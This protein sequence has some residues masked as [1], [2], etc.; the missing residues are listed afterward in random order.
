MPDYKKY[1]IPQ[2]K[3]PFNEYC[4]PQSKSLQIPQT[5]IPQYLKNNPTLRGLLIQWN[6]GS[7]KTCLAIQIIL[8]LKNDYIPIFVMP[9][10]LLPNVYPELMDFCGNNIYMSK[11]EWEK[12]SK[13][14][15]K[16]QFNK[17]KKQIDKDI[18]IYSYNKF[19]TQLTK[20]KLKL[21]NTLLILDEVQNVIS[22]RGKQY[23]I[24][25]NATQNIK[26]IK[27]IPMSATPIYDK[28]NE[29]A[30][31]FNLILP[32]SQ[33]FP[34]GKKFD[35]HF[36]QKTKTKEIFIN[37]DEYKQKIHGHLSYYQGAPKYTFP[38][39][40][41]K[42]KKCPMSPHQSK[43]YL[44]IHNTEHSTQTQQREI[45]DF[46]VQ[47][48]IASNFTY[49]NNQ[50]NEQSIK[51]FKSL[52]LSQLPKYS[53]KMATLLKKVQKSKGKVFIYTNFLKYGGIIP[54]ILSL[55]KAGYKDYKT[56]GL[57]KK[58]FAVWSS[59]ETFNDKNQ[60]KY[61]WNHNSNI[62]GKNI[63]IIIGSP[64]IKEGIS[65][66]ALD[67][68]HIFDMYWNMSR[69][70]QIIGRGSRYCSHKQLPKDE[71]QLLVYI[72]IAILHPNYQSQ[73]KQTIDQRLLN[74]AKKKYS[75]AKQF[76]KANIE[77]SIDCR[78]NYHSTIESLDYK[79]KCDKETL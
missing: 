79:L 10:N 25:Y 38:E 51:Q 16:T 48:R 30:L 46:Y 74:I 17:T 43:F 59:K 69:I 6:M 42:Y 14:F 67:Q 33:Q 28:P 55:E 40:I 49:P 62:K 19:F 71:R 26:N 20:N 32:K 68:L 63:K 41:V 45:N 53:T 8:T 54:I 58:R 44:K 75:I 24:L 37:I 64:S 21:N 66:L 78:L 2:K 34:T 4:N 76:N 50:Y 52:P 13:E 47:S 18:K 3:L 57:G 77:A 70:L 27:I 72:Y 1:Q 23:N 36:I 35:T 5:F 7:G 12:Y 31:I 15:D 65:F 56:H 39:T 29:I 22:D 9:A 73:I 60:L 11:K 61:L